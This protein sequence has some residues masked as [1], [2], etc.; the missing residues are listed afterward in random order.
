MKKPWPEVNGVVN[1]VA[2]DGNGGWYLGGDFQSV[3]GVPRTDLAHVMADGTV[4]PNWAPTTDGLVR[5]LAV[6]AD[7]V[8]AGG[9][10]SAA[11]GAPRG[12]LAGLAR[13]TGAVTTFV[14]SVSFSGSP[15]DPVGVHALLLIGSTL[16]ATGEFNQAQ[17]GLALSVRLRGAAFSI[18]DSQIQ[19]WNP[20]TNRLI[21]GLARD[22][23]GSDLFIGGRFSRVNVTAA[24]PFNTGELRSAV[25]KV[26][27]AA[28]VVNPNWVTPLQAATTSRR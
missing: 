17:S 5:A 24:D 15:F 26:D 7:T 13:A 2:S 20:S 6:G 9:E 1:A 21:N 14:G 23:D 27:E 4:D 25:A 19:A 3:G 11:N 22:S 8:F 18:T 10:F 12:N 28:G 16:Y